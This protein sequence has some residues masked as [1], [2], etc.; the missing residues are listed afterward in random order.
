MKINDDNFMLPYIVSEMI[1]LDVLMGEFK[2]EPIKYY[3]EAKIIKY[4]WL[5]WW[6]EKIV[7][8]VETKFCSIG[9]Y[10]TYEEAA[11][12]LYA[13]GEKVSFKEVT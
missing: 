4:K 5:F 7:Y 10:E 6:F 3:I 9:P 8:R 1:K 2:F 12:M 13:V 11:A